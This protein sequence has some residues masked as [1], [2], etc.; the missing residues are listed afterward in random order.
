MTEHVHEWK[1]QSDGRFWQSD[2]NTL[3]AKSMMW[4]EVEHRLNEYETLKKAT[5]ALSAE[6]AYVGSTYLYQL[7]LTT[8]FPS[9]EARDKTLLLLKRIMAH[10]QAYADILEDK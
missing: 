8:E 9:K 6:D 10:M 2:G 5:D 3:L 1:R 7:A 4:E